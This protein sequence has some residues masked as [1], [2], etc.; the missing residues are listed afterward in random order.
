MVLIGDF[1]NK[2]WSLAL[3]S[4][5]TNGPDG[6]FI[7]QWR[8]IVHNTVSCLEKRSLKIYKRYFKG[9]IGPS[10]FLLWEDHLSIGS[11]FIWYNGKTPVETCQRIERLPHLRFQTLRGTSTLSLLFPITR[12]NAACATK[13]SGPWHQRGGT[14]NR[15]TCLPWKSSASCATRSWRT[16]THSGAMS[17]WC[18]ESRES[19]MLFQ[20]MEGSCLETLLMLKLKS[21]KSQEYL[22]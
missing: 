17:M 21:C 15:F 11:R 5:S 14:L 7:V 9:T 13:S 18:M 20:P 6:R 12:E 16:S 22:S 10:V 4:S 8:T 1:H 3:Q 19:G 2:K